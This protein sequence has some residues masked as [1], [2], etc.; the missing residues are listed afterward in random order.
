VNGITLFYPWSAVD[1]GSGPCTEPSGGANP[2]QWGAV[3]AA[4]QG[5]I[6]GTNVGHTNGLAGHGQK[7]NLI[8]EMVAEAST[9]DTTQIPG[10]VFAAP[11]GS[12]CAQCGPQDMVTCVSAWK[13][14]AGAPTCSGG[15]SGSTHQC[16]DTGYGTPQAGV[17][18]RNVCHLTGNSSNGG[19]S[20]GSSG[21]YTD[22]SG[23]PVLYEA[24]IMKAYQ[25]Y[26]DTVLK[27][28]S[29]QGTGTGPAIG[30][31]IGYIRTGL[32]AGGE[33]LPLCTT[34][35][36]A[37]TTRG[38]WPSPQGLSFDLNPVNGVSPDWFATTSPCT[39]DASC[40]GKYA[41]LGGSPNGVQADGPGY[42]LTN[43][44]TF[45]ASRTNYSGSGFN[46][47]VVANAHA[48]PPSSMPDLS[49][50]DQDA[51]IFTLPCDYC[52]GAGFGEDSLSEYDLD[53]AH[54]CTADWCALFGHYHGYGGNLYLQTTTPNSTPTYAIS[55]ISTAAPYIYGLVTCSNCTAPGGIP[56]APGAGFGGM[57]N[58]E[59]FSLTSGNPPSKVTYEVGQV[60]NA[61]QFTCDPS[62]ACT[63]QGIGLLY[64][65]DYLPD[66]IPFA[67]ANYA[68]TI[69]VYFC[70]WEFAYNPNNSA[71]I[72]CQA[73]VAP[74][75]GYY[76]A[77]LS[78]P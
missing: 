17:W 30:Q 21:P 55:S 9:T 11:Y 42:V 62:T 51:A 43:F 36:I 32:A 48:G 37:G 78:Q 4:L 67:A 52:T 76:A 15:Q 29:A 35:N 41:Y 8:I 12:W 13:G 22:V 45:Q 70:D 38:I 40:Q 61:N 31:Y 69:E 19:A 47:S 33:N 72:G 7:I 34:V 57:Y 28:Y 39:T 58:G 27:H 50:A 26:V 71:A 56:P 1:A 65:G 24:P 54:S 77:I 49:W 64:V 10:Y 53:N 5:Y 14:D 75:S 20:C 73:G 68:S 16:G 74:Y 2:C 25:T 3:D 60:I 23:F 46:P 59:G 6:Q 63:A 18:N 66:T 44:H